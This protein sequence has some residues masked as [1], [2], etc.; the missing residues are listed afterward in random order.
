MPPVQEARAYPA[1]PRPGVVA[2]V[3]PMAQPD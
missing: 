1:A 3:C 2:D